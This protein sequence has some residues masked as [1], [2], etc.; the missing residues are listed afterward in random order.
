MMRLACV[1]VAILSGVPSVVARSDVG[2]FLEPIRTMG[3]SARDRPA[4]YRRPRRARPAA[5]PIQVVFDGRPDWDTGANSIGYAAWAQSEAGLEPIGHATSGT[6]GRAFRD[7]LV[8]R[9]QGMDPADAI[10][11]HDGRRSRIAVFVR[12]ANRLPDGL[13]RRLTAGLPDGS[14]CPSA[15]R[16]S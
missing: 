8:Y 14:V 1:L 10:A 5:C 2:S 13:C 11:M 9:I 15:P 16:S 4:A 12:D 3:S 7:H 6:V